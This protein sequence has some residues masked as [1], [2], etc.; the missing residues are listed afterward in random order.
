MTASAA[1][2]QHA[3]CERVASG[4]ALP[5]PLGQP[6]DAAVDQ[7]LLLKILAGFWATFL[8]LYVAR[9]FL[10]DDL[11][12]ITS[13]PRR[14]VVSAA[15][16]GL[17]WLM[18][19]T[20][21]RAA[22]RRTVSRFLWVGG[23]SLAAGCAFAAINSFGFYMLSP[24]T[25]ERCLEGA[26]CAPE[27][28]W[29]LAKEY[30]VNFSFVFAAWGM[31]YLWMTSTAETLAANRR[32]AHAREAA[33]TAEI[34]ALRYQV[35]PHFLFNCLNSLATLVNRKDVGDAQEMIDELGAF[36]RYGL[37]ADPV[38]DV[39]LAD[40][41]DMQL[42]YL[43]LERRRFAHRMTVTVDAA[44]AVKRARVPSLILQPLV[45]NAIKHGVANT[46]AP[47]ALTLQAG[48]TASGDLRIVVEDDAWTDLTPETPVGLG[49]GLRNVAERLTARF[50]GAATLDAG[51]IPGGGFRVILTMPLVL[52]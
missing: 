28:L 45:E 24:L 43:T 1:M 49:I 50:G 46:S 25:N 4:N 48:R 7:R 31:L 41:I 15:G 11:N 27:F 52:A 44:D 32:T 39:E 8:L 26:P 5:E 16:A 9:T 47:V 34:R 13:I 19:R 30:S 18:Y 51:P 3:P 22:P 29:L 17:S 42:R 12:P 2:T 35:N 14:V 23:L 10:I 6:R 20:L 37:A 36:L 33:R 38:A 40:E 21:E